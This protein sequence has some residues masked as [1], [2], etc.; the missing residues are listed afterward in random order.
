MANNAPDFGQLV[1]YIDEQGVHS[2][3]LGQHSLDVLPTLQA[4]Q[5]D[6]VKVAAL[7]RGAALDVDA[8]TALKA[9][10]GEVYA[11]DVLDNEFGSDDPAAIVDNLI[12]VRS[13]TDWGAGLAVAVGDVVFYAG[14]LYTCIQA[15]TTQSDWPPD[16]TLALWGRYYQGGAVAE[17]VSGEAGVQVGDLRIYEG[18]TYECIQNPGVNIWPPPTVPAL[19]RAV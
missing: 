11:Q 19:W 8:L 9:A 5:A 16:T 13:H 14:N 18:V 10:A 17:W 7:G 1:E 2:V 3:P 15:H 4:V 12:A 6:Y